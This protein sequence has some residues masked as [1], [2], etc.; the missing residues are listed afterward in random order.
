MLKL[1]SF[2][3]ADESV[4]PI[5]SLTK[6]LMSKTRLRFSN[7]HESISSNLLS[8]GGNE[9]RSSR[10]QFL[11]VKSKDYFLSDSIV[12]TRHYESRHIYGS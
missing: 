8:Y 5:I 11:Y 2:N 10:G 7:G 12:S 3:A 1:I 4:K 9:A 6:K